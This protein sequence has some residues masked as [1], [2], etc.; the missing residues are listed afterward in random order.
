M[1]GVAPR[2]R[3][4]SATALVSASVRWATTWSVTNAGFAGRG[5]SN[6][7]SIDGGAPSSW[8]VQ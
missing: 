5:R 2:A 8:S 3:A 1:N 7:R 6:G 4:A